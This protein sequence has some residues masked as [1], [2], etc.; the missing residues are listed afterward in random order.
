MYANRFCVGT[1]HWE[2]VSRLSQFVDWQCALPL[3]SIR[4][5]TAARGKDLCLMV[6]GHANPARWGDIWLELLKG[7]VWRAP[8][9]CK[10]TAV[11]A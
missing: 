11:I 8:Q 3:S 5:N 10:R 4:A 9:S 2:P 1:N 7:S 6:L